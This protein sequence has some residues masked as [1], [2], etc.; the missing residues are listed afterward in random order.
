MWF[1]GAGRP[2]PRRGAPGAAGVPVRVLHETLEPPEDPTEITIPKAAVAKAGWL[3]KRDLIKLHGERA[4]K[5]P[6][7]IPM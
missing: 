2:S 6:T 3:P 1:G 4:M 7:L 5:A